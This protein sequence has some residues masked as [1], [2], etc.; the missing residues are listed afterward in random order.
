MQ[1]MR[2][3]RFYY[4]IM[5]ALVFGFGYLTYLILKPFFSPIGWAIVFSIVFYPLYAFILRY[6]KSPTLAATLTTII[7]LVIILGPLS[8]FLYLLA[9]ELSN[10]SIQDTSLDGLY[11]VFDHPYIKPIVDRI[12]AFSHIKR[13]QFQTSVVGSLSGMGKVLLGYV[14][15]R[16]GDI[17]GVMVSFVLMVFALF[18]FLKDGDLFL[19]KAKDYIPF[20]G[21]Q[22]ERVA[23]QIKD[24]IISTIYGGLV[25]ALLQGLCAGLGFMFVGFSSPVLWG[26]ATSIASFIPVFGS[27]LV[28]GPAAFYLLFTGYIAKGIVLLFI[29][30]F[31][32]GL[33]DN[34]LRPL[35]I[36]GRTSMPL[37]VILFSVLGGIE[38]FGLIGIVLGPLV[39][40]VFLSLLEIFR[41]LEGGEA[42]R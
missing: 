40:A 28:W 6:I 37:L 27:F 42:G 15:S 2:E 21:R 4:L 35:L 34:L 7:T 41:D 16:L 13:T 24:I 30:V 3:N 19:A 29:G 10:I 1:G 38:V 8:T 5:L 31:I 39:L 32:I 18:F 20:S 11:R 33:V 9:S 14:P 17:A 23:K 26:L 36:R 22:K 25:V 12:L